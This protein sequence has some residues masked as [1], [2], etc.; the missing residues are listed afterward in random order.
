MAL[1]W[2]WYSQKA[3]RM[4]T[5]FSR[6]NNPQRSHERLQI[7]KAADEWQKK[8]EERSVITQTAQ[9]GLGRKSQKHLDR[10]SV[11]HKKKEARV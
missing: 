9:T 1:A 4:R 2:E 10:G 11:R 7:P 3:P 6:W 5:R 8:L